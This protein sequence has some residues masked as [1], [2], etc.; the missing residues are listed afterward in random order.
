MATKKN[1]KRRHKKRTFLVNRAIEL[2]GLLL[3][4]LSFLVVIAFI[5][6]DP[7][8][9]SFNT[10]SD[11]EVQNLAGTVGAYLIA[12]L[13]SFLGYGT[14]A[15]ALIA[16]AWG[17]KML[18]KSRFPHPFLHSIS[19]ALTL[20]LAAMSASLF[21]PL[22][23]PP[24]NWPDQSLGLGGFIGEYALSSITPLIPNIWLGFILIPLFCISL[25]A[26]M[27]LRFSQWFIAITFSLKTVQWC[28]NLL[29]AL[30]T[31]IT[32]SLADLL[33]ASDYDDELE[34][35]DA[36]ADSDG[37]KTKKK[38][39][40]KAA[41]DKAPKKRL[42]MTKNDGD[43]TE[44]TEDT[45]PAASKRKAA[46]AKPIVKTNKAMAESDE[47]EF[48]DFIQNS[49]DFTM[50][51]NYQ[52]PP[53]DLL[54]K[55][56]RT[57]QT[58]SESSLS[59]NAELLEKVLED[60]GI[61]GKIIEVRPGPVVTLYAL[62]PSPGTKSARVIG[63]ADDIARSMSATSARIAVIP[64]QNAIGIELPNA[65]RATVYLR[66]LIST[67]QFKESGLNLPL[68]LGKDIGGEPVLIDLAKTPHMLV[69]GTTG[70]GKSVG[71][72][73]MILSLL[74]TYSPEECKFIMIDPK[75]LELSIYA[76]IPHLL[77]P[78]VT[79][80]GKAVTAL[81]WTVKEME[82]RYKMMSN[83][84]VRNI[85]GYNDKI[86]EAQAKGEELTRTVQTG[87]D[88]E[89]GKPIIET[90]AMDMSLL[91]F[92]VVIVDEMA[93]LMLVG[94]KEIETSVQRLAQ[95][96]RA[97]G[98]HVVLATQRPSVDVITGIIKANFPTRLSFQ[99]SSKIDSRTILGEPGAEQLLGMGDMLYLGTGNR[100]LRV[101]GPFVSD[102]EVQRVVDF[103]KKHGEPSYVSEVLI[104]DEAD[105][106]TADADDERDDM[107]EKA[108]EIVRRDGKAST[109]YVQRSL[110][111][112]YNRA[113]NIIDQMERDGVISKAD[114]VGRREVL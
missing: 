73:T 56:K 51:E 107:Y 106:D 114:H 83:I 53:I 72:N 9:P 65:D 69:A 59:H 78:V 62:E 96:A 91:P 6:F 81:K 87:F 94:G 100:L 52:L 112:G 89:T 1:V 44:D 39:V 43:T 18:L 88:N 60:Y 20:P 76:D 26:A 82:N 15:L 32:S 93:D 41:K 102:Q 37:S 4:G 28:I 35:D 57:K 45:P 47:D 101:H 71:I 68:A 5:S 10:S 12:P 80:P 74:Y 79:E 46:K 49:M 25:C 111:I 16:C 109:S 36:Q 64:G 108:L 77:A 58:L 50:I 3:L 54:Q 110:R 27:G 29:F 67:K 31:K 104:D 103:V 13:I 17:I 90:V 63:L 42:I 75:M 85:Y 66:E 11:H 21:D 95:M 40:R 98:I 105:G 8:D 30:T 34:E 7:S 33:E 99:V 61:R 22:T 38:A 24:A 14:L 70:S 48:E 2:V 23:L 84:G 92:I 19:L 113:A 97:A 86:R 55:P